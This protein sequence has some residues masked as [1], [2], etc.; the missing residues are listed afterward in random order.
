MNCYA[1][2]A[3]SGCSEKIKTVKTTQKRFMSKFFE[4]QCG[5][6][7]PGSTKCGQLDK[8]PEAKVEYTGKFTRAMT[9][10]FES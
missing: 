5:E 6:Y 3:A 7:V 2:F 9:G 1:D 10:V 4:T 8:L